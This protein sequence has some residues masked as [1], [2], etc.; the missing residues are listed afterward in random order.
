VT[1]LGGLTGNADDGRL[2]VVRAELWTLRL[3]LLAEPASPQRTK[4]WPPFGRVG[5]A[6]DRAVMHRVAAA[7][8]RNFLAS[9]AAVLT[10]QLTESSPRSSD[11]QLR[12]ESPGS[13]RPVTESTRIRIQTGVSV[14]CGH[15]CNP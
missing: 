12:I 10:R 2:A 1:V 9:V 14:A 5:E 7:T 13:R 4:D 11:S 6:M 8:V 15:G 3:E